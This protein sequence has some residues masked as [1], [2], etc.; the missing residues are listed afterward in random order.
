MGCDF[1]TRE[2]IEPE[3][4]IQSYESRCPVTTVQPARLDF[5]IVKYAPEV[6]VTNQQLGKIQAKLELSATAFKDFK[7]EYKRDGVWDRNG[8]FT[9]VWLLSV[10]TKLEKCKGLFGL[11]VPGGGEYMDKVQGKSLTKSMLRAAIEVTPHFVPAKYRQ[12]PDF[13]SYL[14]AL[15]KK[16]T[17]ATIQLH[18]LVFATASVHTVDSL[19]G[20][21]S[22]AHSGLLT[23][24]GLRRYVETCQAGLGLLHS[25]SEHLPSIK[26][27]RFME[28][29]PAST[30][31]TV[32][33]T[34]QRSIL[35]NS[36]N[37][38]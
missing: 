1:S 26:R 16:L 18:A 30:P 14:E 36:P 37:I 11:F 21:F 8:L 23:M 29:G 22:G 9:A 6:V 4:R 15:R 32:N 33:P 19:L 31:A 28:E 25:S 3:D 27:I 7:G 2:R 35:K 5:V 12:L 17:S 10:A 24:H 20:V 38:A 34:P 13:Q